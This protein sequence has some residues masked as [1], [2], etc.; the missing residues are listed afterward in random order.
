MLVTLDQLKNNLTDT[1]TLVKSYMDARI[2][3][4]LESDMSNIYAT[5]V[6]TPE[7]EGE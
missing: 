3:A 4:E 2:R 1:L 6:V 7:E 5:A